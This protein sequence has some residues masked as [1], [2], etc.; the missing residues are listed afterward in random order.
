MLQPN[1]KD[2]GQVPTTE[3]PRLLVVIDTEEEFDLSLMHQRSAD[4]E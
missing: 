2:Y 1:P 3:P 4:A